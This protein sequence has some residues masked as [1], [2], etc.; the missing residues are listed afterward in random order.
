MPSTF[1]SPTFPL[2]ASVRMEALFDAWVFAA[3]DATLALQAWNDTRPRERQVAH[4]VYRAA[5]DRE[6]S[7]AEALWQAS[8]GRR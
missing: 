2:R 3:H 7:A 5:L 4:A 8:A 6:E 1:P